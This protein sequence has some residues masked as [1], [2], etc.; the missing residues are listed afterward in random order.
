MVRK[1]G[2][3]QVADFDDAGGG[4][5]N[6]RWFEVTMEDMGIVEIEETVQE[7]IGERLE[8]L[9]PVELRWDRNHVRRYDALEL[10]LAHVCVC[11]IDFRG[12]S[13]G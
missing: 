10:S 11:I 6:V 13:T 3:S 5:E 8:V 12:T 1:T 7:L 4:Y 2:E 9:R